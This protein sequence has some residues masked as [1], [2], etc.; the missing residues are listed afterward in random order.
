M[1]NEI[2]EAIQKSLP[3]MQMDALKAELAK[4]ERLPALEKQIELL[5]KSLEEENKKYSDMTSKYYEVNTRAKKTDELNKQENE[6]KVK[7]LELE[8]K[9]EKEAS[10]RVEALAMA[11][12]RNPTVHK[13]YYKNETP[14][15]P[16]YGNLN[17]ST[18]GGET[19]SVD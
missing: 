13:S 12:F 19:V 7:M 14:A 3:S 5:N 8:L 9:L 18:N 17:S 15:N 4:L 16:S 10:K 6:L 2:L 11:A 1:N